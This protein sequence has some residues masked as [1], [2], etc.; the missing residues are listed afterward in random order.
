MNLYATTDNPIPH[1]AIVSPVR[2]RDG[3]TLRAARWTMREAQGTVVVLTGRS[4]FIE[5]YFGVIRA[6]LARNFEVVALDWR[7]QGQSDREIRQ[8]R[9][10]YVSDFGGYRL[11]LESLERQVLDP[12][13]RKPWFAFAHS[14]GAAV[15]LEQAHDGGS[16]FQRLF[17]CAPML[18]L[19]LRFKRFIKLSTR[20]ADRLGLG[21]RLIPGGTE[22]PIFVKRFEGNVLTTD[23]LQ[24]RRLAMTIKELPRLAVGAPTIRWLTSAFAL[25]ERLTADPHFAV[26]ILT[27]IL[28]VAAGEDRIVDTAATERFALGLKVGRCLTLAGARHQVMMEGPDIDAQLWAAFDA[29]IPGERGAGIEDETGPT[30]P[31]REALATS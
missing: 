21:T 28:I 24:H 20:I 3:L 11:D 19:P 15:V 5:T 10:G 7:G 17:L 29:F 12:Y 1:G 31:R 14:M 22:E 4:E 27:P 2:T 9:R 8:E 18:D 23:R 16:P 25:M 30:T 26:E 13:A 6:L